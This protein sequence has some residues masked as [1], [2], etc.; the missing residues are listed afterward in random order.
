MCDLWGHAL[1]VQWS[2]MQYNKTDTS[3]FVNWVSLWDKVPTWLSLEPR[4]YK[5]FATPGDWALLFWVEDLA[6]FKRQGGFGSVQ[7]VWDNGQCAEH[8]LGP[9]PPRIPGNPGSPVSPW[10]RIWQQHGFFRKCTQHDLTS[11][12]LLYLWLKLTGCPLGPLSPCGPGSPIP[13]LKPLFPGGPLW[14]RRP[15]SPWMDQ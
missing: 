8:T 6:M 11:L 9:K 3:V 13:P 15:C 10:E 7:N 4:S 2:E 12:K 14:P 1:L 5:C